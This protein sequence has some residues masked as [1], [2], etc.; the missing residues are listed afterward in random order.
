MW[1]CVPVCLVVV[2]SIFDQ[3]LVDMSFISRPVLKKVLQLA[4]CVM[5]EQIEGLP[6]HHLL[7]VEDIVGVLTTLLPYFCTS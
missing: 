4:R 7:T 5:L 2:L 3:R 1:H 6:K